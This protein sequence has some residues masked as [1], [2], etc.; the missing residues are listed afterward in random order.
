VSVIFL[1]HFSNYA[2]LGSLVLVLIW[3]VNLVKQAFLLFE[4]VFLIFRVVKEQWQVL[5]VV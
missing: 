2:R 4:Y 5:V 1:A 3:Y